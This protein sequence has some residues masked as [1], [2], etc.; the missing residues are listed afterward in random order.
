M[1]AVPAA[2]IE[3]MKAST[4]CLIL[5]M[6]GLLPVIGL[7]CALAA[8][9]LAGRI[10]AREKQ[11]WNPAQPYRLIGVACAAVGTIGWLVI[12]LLIAMQAVSHGRCDSMCGCGGLGWMV[13]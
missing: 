1:T 3:L 13:E 9:W 8:L 6:L 10:R 2:K 5:G 11:L 7:P 4:R 12:G